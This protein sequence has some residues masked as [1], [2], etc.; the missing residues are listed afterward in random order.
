MKKINSPHSNRALAVGWQPLGKLDLPV[1]PGLEKNLEV[2]LAELLV[3]LNLQMD[4]LNRLLRSSQEATRR[5]VSSADKAT[6]HIRHIHL[7]IF[8]PENSDVKGK[9]WGFF[10]IERLEG[11]VESSNVPN[12]TI[13][14]YL[15]MEDR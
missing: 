6:H 1:G 7:H 2:R 5:A 10:R 15:Y 13:E 11:Q 4:F 3:P 14:L 12:H 9:T 8:I